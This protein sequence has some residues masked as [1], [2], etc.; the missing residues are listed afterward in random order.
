MGERE[1][2]ESGTCGG[3]RKT[4]L[5]LGSLVTDCLVVLH[6]LQLDTKGV[7]GVCA[8]EPVLENKESRP[9]FLNPCTVDLGA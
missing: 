1:K 7:L 6:Q 2:G 9:G 8:H 4:R 5:S 3:N